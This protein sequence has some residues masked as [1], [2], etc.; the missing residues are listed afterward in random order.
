MSDSKK[1]YEEMKYNTNTTARMEA[2]K[3]D[4]IVE[5]VK[6][7]MDERSQKGQRDYGTTLQDSP[8]DFY[9]WLNHLQEELM[10][11]ALYIQKIKK[12]K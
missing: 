12:L 1:K 3:K 7:I 9:S 8:D 4:S 6:Y 5:D 11:A 10:D 2:I